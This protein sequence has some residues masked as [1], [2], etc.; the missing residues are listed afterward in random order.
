M[1]LV[2]TDSVILKT[3]YWGFLKKGNYVRVS[4]L[5]VKSV[6]HLAGIYQCQRSKATLS[7]I[8]G[9]SLNEFLPDLGP[10]HSPQA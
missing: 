4:H 6:H 1:Y 3:G 2:M 10:C 9:L 7:S 5:E 8:S